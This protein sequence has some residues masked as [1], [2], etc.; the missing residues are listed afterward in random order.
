VSERFYSVQTYPPPNA[1]GVLLRLIDGLGYR[2]Y[3]AIEGL[4]ADDASFSPGHGAMSIDKLIEHVWGLFNWIHLNVLGAAWPEE[5]PS[6]S[7]MFVYVIQHA[8]DLGYVSAELY[9]P[10]VRR[11]YDGLHAK[12]VVNEQ[13]LIDIYDA[14][15]GVC[16][17]RSYANYVNYPKTVNAKEAVGGVLWATTVVKKPAR[18]RQ[19]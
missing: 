5:R 2:F 11:G 9:R 4:T 6:G 16:V 17:R 14:C 3:W 19:T 10:V 18:R 8:I 13:G 15:D 7:A 1:N 12:V